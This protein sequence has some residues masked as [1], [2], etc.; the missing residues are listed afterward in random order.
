M[1]SNVRVPKA[2]L[3]LFK[4]RVLPRTIFQQISKKRL[5]NTHDSTEL[6]A[7]HI[8]LSLR[9]LNSYDNLSLISIKIRRNNMVLFANVA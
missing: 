6:I 2:W 8:I 4:V 1:A 9:R 3:D 5:P 7:L